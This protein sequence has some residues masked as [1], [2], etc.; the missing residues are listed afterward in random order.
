MDIWRK[1]LEN[2][3]PALWRYTQTKRRKTKHIS[4]AAAAAA[5]N[6]THYEQ[7]KPHTHVLYIELLCCVRI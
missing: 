7:R 2:M 3:K 4:A 5:G 1:A 6:A